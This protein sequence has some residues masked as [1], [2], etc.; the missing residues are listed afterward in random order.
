M[1]DRHGAEDLAPVGRGDPS[2]RPQQG[3][4]VRGPHAH[5]LTHIEQSEAQL[6][7]L[8]LLVLPTLS[9]AWFRGGGA[10]KCRGQVWRR[11]VAQ[12]DVGVYQAI[13]R[14]GAQHGAVELGQHVKHLRP[15]RLLIRV[16]QMRRRAAGAGGVVP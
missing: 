6:L 9:R 13:L 10:P 15:Q 11:H 1:L 12:M 5:E 2:E 4:G 7:L 3:F 8:L 14:E 16:G